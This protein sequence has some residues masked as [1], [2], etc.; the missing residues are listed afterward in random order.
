MKQTK[1]LLNNKI[2]EYIRSSD[3]KKSQKDIMDYIEKQCPE[4]NVTKSEIAYEIMAL[5][6]NWS[7]IREID[8]TRGVLWRRY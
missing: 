6:T 1:Q 8:K 4:L 5:R 3:A 2:V 7:I